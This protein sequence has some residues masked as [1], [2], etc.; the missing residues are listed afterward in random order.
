MIFN[1]INVNLP[2]C[3]KAQSYCADKA[4]KLVAGDNVEGFQLPPRGILQY[5]ASLL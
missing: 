3:Q 4:C 2:R 5:V 1:R